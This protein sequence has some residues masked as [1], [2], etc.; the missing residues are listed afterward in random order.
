M[1]YLRTVT[2][3]LCA[4]TAIAATAGPRLRWLST[5]SDFGAFSEE[6]GKVTAL[7]KA[8]NEG[9]EPVV[10]IEARANCGCTT[11]R[12]STAPVDPGDTLTV[13]V[14]YDPD[15]RP[16]RFSKNV[17]V[18][19][20]TEP[21]RS[22]LIIKGVV[23]GKPATVAAR[24]PVAMGP[25]LMSRSAELLGVIRK[26]HVRVEFD[27][28]YSRA[29]RTLR[30]AFR[31]CPAW[32]TVTAAPDTLPP[33]EQF[34]LNFYVN[35]DKTP[36]YGVVQDTITIIPDPEG[37]PDMTYPLPVIATFEE[38]FS[39][40]T[41]GQ[42]AKAPV[43]DLR[44]PRIDLVAAEGGFIN[45]FSSDMGDVIRPDAEGRITVTYPVRNTGRLPLFVRRVYTTTPGVALKMSDTKIKPGK[46]AS[47]AVTVAAPEAGHTVNTRITVITNDPANPTQTLRLTVD[48]PVRTD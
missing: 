46:T 34:T 15:G 1:K 24:Y 39:R 19:T 48:N 26:G 8:V 2:V 45:V 7:F 37:A 6:E 40:L 27:R 44:L 31:D 18:D 36:L 16:G 28:G 22:K 11:P 5:V 42:R 35:P 10:V 3:V 43:A 9:D 30:P 4:A 13:S 17:Y 47:L 33:G 32:L 12:Y 23:I 14:S 38:D 41:P 29:T 21:S 25:L 20:N